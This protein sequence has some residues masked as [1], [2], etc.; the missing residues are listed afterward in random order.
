MVKLETSLTNPF[1]TEMLL[2][3]MRSAI[4]TLEQ[5]AKNGHLSDHQTHALG[6]MAALVVHAWKTSVSV[7][8]TRWATERDIDRESAQA[9]DEAKE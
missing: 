1:D 3:D 8:A 5:R 7:M 9:R 4:L 6:E 2:R